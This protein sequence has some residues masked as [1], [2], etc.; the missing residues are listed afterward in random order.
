MG[1]TGLSKTMRSGNAMISSN[2]TMGAEAKPIYDGRGRLLGHAVWDGKLSRKVKATDDVSGNTGQRVRT[3]KGGI[4]RNPDRSIGERTARYEFADVETAQ[5]DPNPEG[6][7]HQFEIRPI[8]DDD[9]RTYSNEEV[10]KL[11]KAAVEF[12]NGPYDDGP[13]QQATIPKSGPSQ[14]WLFREDRN[15]KHTGG[16]FLNRAQVETAAEAAQKK[17]AAWTFLELLKALDLPCSREWIDA[18]NAAIREFPVGEVKKAALRIAVIRIIHE[19]HDPYFEQYLRDGHCN[20]RDFVYRDDNPEP[21]LGERMADEEYTRGAFH[22]PFDLRRSKSKDKKAAKYTTETDSLYDHPILNEWAESLRRKWRGHGPDTDG[23]PEGVMSPAAEPSRILREILGMPRLD[24]RRRKTERPKSPKLRVVERAGLPKPR[25]WARYQPSAEESAEW[26]RYLVDAHHPHRPEHVEPAKRLLPLPKSFSSI[27]VT[28]TQR[29]EGREAHKRILALKTSKSSAWK[30]TVWGADALKEFTVSQRACLHLNGLEPLFRI[31]FCQFRRVR[32]WND[33]PTYRWHEP[34][35]PFYDE[36]TRTYGFKR[37][38][39]E[40]RGL[41]RTPFTIWNIETWASKSLLPLGS[42]H[43]SPSLVLHAHTMT[44]WDLHCERIETVSKNPP[45]PHAYGV[46]ES[47]DII[48]VLPADVQRVRVLYSHQWGR[49]KGRKKSREL[50]PEEIADPVI[51]PRGMCKMDDR[52]RYRLDWVM[53]NELAPHAVM[54]WRVNK[55]ISLEKMFPPK[56]GRPNKWA[57]DQ[58]KDLQDSQIQSLGEARAVLGRILT[59]DFTPD[60]PCVRELP[61]G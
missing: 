13:P 59:A 7:G 32:L 18:L 50:R 43:V 24:V 22:S 6:V 48:D 58:Y 1:C 20:V 19:R 16:K 49:D 29:D 60:H 51:V 52:G 57:R 61:A 38:E 39:Q 41:E 31:P 42:R 3:R 15:G 47:A 36:R 55:E 9:K 21:V 44:G 54:L 14:S 25:V 30:H 46:R 45:R 33:F 2:D 28:P 35:R 26:N 4:I 12:P 10:L 56:R 23:A 5:W 17:S 8:D 53:L 40:R 11:H 27:P 34:R 37:R